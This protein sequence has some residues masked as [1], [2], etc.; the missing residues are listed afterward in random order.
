VGY[1]PPGLARLATPGCPRLGSHWDRCG[2]HYVEVE[3]SRR[4]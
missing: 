2:V 4:S 1:A 3:N